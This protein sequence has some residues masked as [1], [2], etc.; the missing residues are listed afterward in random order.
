MQPLFPLHLL[1]LLS[2]LSTQGKKQARL[3]TLAQ[4]HLDISRS[5]I[6]GMSCSH[7]KETETPEKDTNESVT[8]YQLL[9][10]ASFRSGIPLS[11]LASRDGCGPCGLFSTAGGTAAAF[12]TRYHHQH[13]QSGPWAFQNRVEGTRSPISPLSLLLLGMHSIPASVP[14][15]AFTPHHVCVPYPL[16]YYG[17]QVSAYVDPWTQGRSSLVLAVFEISHKRDRVSAHTSSAQLNS[18]HL[19]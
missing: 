6:M 7:E 10:L 2:H 14:Q 11:I 9:H 15:Q 19:D 12:P 3:H 17:P 8:C 18:P 5:S 4:P 1:S 16:H 13:R